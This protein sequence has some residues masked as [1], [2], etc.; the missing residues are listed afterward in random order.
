MDLSPIAWPLAQLYYSQ[1]NHHPVL[2]A[3]ASIFSISE[4][5]TIKKCFENSHEENNIT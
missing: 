3:N 2:A 5:P 1:R 4:I